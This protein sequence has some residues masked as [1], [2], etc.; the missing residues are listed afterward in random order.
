MSAMIVAGADV[1]GPLLGPVAGSLQTALLG[2][3]GV[4]LGI[5][6]TVWALKNAWLLLKGLVADPMVRGMTWNYDGNHPGGAMNERGES[7]GDSTASFNERAEDYD[8]AA[9]AYGEA[10]DKAEEATRLEQDAAAISY[11]DRYR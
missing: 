2:V 1:L 7:F 8:N 6:V 3:G 5:G 10:A 4:A 11:L 9:E